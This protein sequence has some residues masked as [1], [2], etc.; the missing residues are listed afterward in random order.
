VFLSSESVSRSLE[1]FAVMDLFSPP[2]L[3]LL[4]TAS[5]APGPVFSPFAEIEER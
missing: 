1:I 3:N 4:N 2:F 5:T